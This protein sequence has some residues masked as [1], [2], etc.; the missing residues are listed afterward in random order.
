MSSQVVEV[1][2]DLLS[3]RRAEAL[4]REMEKPA[5]ERRE[6]AAVVVK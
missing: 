6:A 1:L 3:K 4:R 2:S 5:E